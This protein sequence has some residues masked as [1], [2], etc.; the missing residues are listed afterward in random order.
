MAKNKPSRRLQALAKDFIVDAAPPT[1][2]ASARRRR[3]TRVLP[4]GA[5][6]R[7]EW[8]ITEAEANM[9]P[10][11][12]LSVAEVAALLKVRGRPSAIVRLSAGDLLL[13]RNVVR[14]AYDRS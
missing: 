1:A 6:D 14:W 11:G 12:S 5:M 8:L 9:R 13:L 4:K 10:D 2:A 7:L 3:Y